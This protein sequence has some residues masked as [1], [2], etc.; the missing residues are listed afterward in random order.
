MRTEVL[1]D[2]LA[3]RAAPAR[4]LP[5]PIWRCM[6]W[7]VL[8]VVFAAAMVAVMSP[9]PDVA[10]R[11]A[12]PGFLF[13]QAMAFLTAALA[14]HAALSL[15]VPG[16][17][18]RVALLPAIPAALWI[19]AQG[20][21]CIAALTRTGWSLSPEPECLFYIAVT[22]SVPAVGIVVM[23]RRGLAVRPRLALALA[24]LAAAALGSV[25]LRFFHSQDAAL[26]VMI[27]QTGSVLLLSLAG[28]AAG[29]LVLAGRRRPA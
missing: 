6:R 14:A 18:A 12:D 26:M 22:G 3:A 24:V 27:W 13:E 16:T 15:S 20:V 19:G 5:A 17:S 9:R 10:A 7:M 28:W 4:P 11:M 25:G 8:A 2:R 23:M 1:I 21:G 29:R